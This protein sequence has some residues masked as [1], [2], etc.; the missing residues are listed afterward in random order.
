MVGQEPFGR[1]GVVDV[2]RLSECTEEIYIKEA[3]HASA[4][5]SRTISSVIGRASGRTSNFGSPI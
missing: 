2:C 4:I 1:R 3:L 5:A